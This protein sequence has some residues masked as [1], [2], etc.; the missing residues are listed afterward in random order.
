MGDQVPHIAGVQ[1]IEHVQAR[2][3]R[4]SGLRRWEDA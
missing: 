2:I 3:G 1:I 4:L